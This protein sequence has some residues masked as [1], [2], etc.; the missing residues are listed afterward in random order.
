[1]SRWLRAHCQEFDVAYI[2]NLRHDSFAAVGT[3]LK[4]PVGVVLRVRAGDCRWLE[5]SLLG[6][7]VRRRAG[8]ADALVAPTQALQRESLAAGFPPDRIHTI[9]NGVAVAEEVLPAQRHAARA[10]LAEINHSL[11]AA[12]YAPIAVAVG[13]LLEGRNLPELV[14]SWRFVAARWPSA[15]LW[16]VGDGSLREPL[17]ERI[18]DHGLHHQVH[19]PGTFDDLSDILAAADLFVSPA[20]SLDGGQHLLAAM[21]AGLPVIAARGSESCELIEH[22]GTGLIL[23]T[24]DRAELAEAIGELLENPR[25]AALYGQAGRRRV[26]CGFSPLQTCQAHLQLFERIAA[27]KRRRF[28]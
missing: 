5:T 7:R 12:E 16:I 25:R 15:K 6:G 14:E 18:V 11:S 19:L 23:P 27:E 10:S 26:Q 13:P 24:A 22:R 8:L 4:Q 3:L 9:P 20:A 17:Y 1:L 21:A 28:P 2:M